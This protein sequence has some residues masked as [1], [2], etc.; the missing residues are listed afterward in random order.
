MPEPDPAVVA[1]RTGRVLDVA[2]SVLVVEVAD[3]TLSSD[4]T[5]KR[6]IYAEAGAPRYWIVEIRERQVR[7]LE[8]PEAGEYQS[9]RVIHEGGGGPR[10][11][12][13]RNGYHLGASRQQLGKG[14]WRARGSAGLIVP[15]APG[16]RSGEG[17]QDGRLG[18]G[19]PVTPVLKGG[20]RSML[21]RI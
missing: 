14:R 11:S 13:G 10:P 12:H 21:R 19:G 5:V 2:E 3:T 1:A 16:R 15:R 8:E 18:P 20:R 4:R 9:E 6:R 7:V 17:G